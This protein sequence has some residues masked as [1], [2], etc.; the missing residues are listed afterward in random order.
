MRRARIL[1]PHDTCQTRET[2]MIFAYEYGSGARV[3]CWVLCDKRGL[4]EQTSVTSVVCTSRRAW[5]RG[6]GW[7]RFTAKTKTLWDQSSRIRREVEWVEGNSSTTKVTWGSIQ[8]AYSNVAGAYMCTFVCVCVCLHRHV[9][10]CSYL[11]VYRN[12]LPGI[13]MYI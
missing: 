8:D 9:H 5:T 11:L 13:R 4:Y 2:I 1:L 3:T 6:G 7:V 10:A 12:R